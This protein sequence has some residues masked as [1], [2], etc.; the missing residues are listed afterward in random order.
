[1]TWLNVISFI[2]TPALAAFLTEILSAEGHINVGDVGRMVKALR[3]W[4]PVV[5]L[6]AILSL[7][8]IFHEEINISSSASGLSVDF[9]WGYP[10]PELKI[11]QI[12]Y[13]QLRPSAEFLKF[14]HY[15]TKEVLFSSDRSL[16][17]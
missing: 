12:Y 8:H 4:G 15:S 16:D 17:R 11:L 7:S 3:E 5:L 13:E 10:S 6:M 2:T 1:M 14:Y 9:H